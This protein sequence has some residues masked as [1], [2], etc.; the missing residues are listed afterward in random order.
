MVPSLAEEIRDLHGLYGSSRD[1]EAR[2]F[3]PLADAYRR[4]GDAE[5]ALEVLTAGLAR[6]PDFASAHLVRGMAEQDRGNVEGAARAFRRVLELDGDNARALLGLGRILVDGGDLETGEELIDRGLALDP[7]LLERE[8]GGRPPAEPGAGDDPLRDHGEDSGAEAIATAAGAAEGAEAAVDTAG[9]LEAVEWEVIDIDAL[10][11][12]PADLP[13]DEVGG[14]AEVG[15]AAEVAEA[16]DDEEVLDIAL[17][18]PDPGVTSD[19]VVTPDPEVTPDPA[20]TPA[21]APP[22][23]A[24]DDEPFGFSLDASGDAELALDWDLADEEPDPPAP[25]PAAPPPDDEELVVDA[26]SLAPDGWVHGGAPHVGGD[27]DLRRQ[28]ADLT[29]D[30]EP[31]PPPAESDEPEEALPTRT[32]GELYARQGLRSEAVKVFEALVARSPDDADLQARLAELRGAPPAPA[33]AAPAAAPPPPPTP[34]LRDELDGPPVGDYFARLLAWNAGE[35]ADGADRE[36]SGD[37][38]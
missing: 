30:L 8:F 5:R 18:S 6:H 7:S 10:R 28:L 25:S 11:P 23:A 35:A 33:A 14:V 38:D 16:A 26:A 32:L 24:A 15:A 9:D 3:V 22:V 21:D 17:L 19:A 34:S 27:D 29:A 37:R 2:A 36:S 13:E 4:S 20:A 1:P 31:A 12:T